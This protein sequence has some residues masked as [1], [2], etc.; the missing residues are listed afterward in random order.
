MHELL[1]EARIISVPAAG[2]ILHFEALEAYP[3][4]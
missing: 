3:E 1:P 4:P 2:H